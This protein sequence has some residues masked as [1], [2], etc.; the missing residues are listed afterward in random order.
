MTTLS[1]SL[2]ACHWPPPQPQG[3]IPKESN[4][5]VSVSGP[6]LE[7]LVSYEGHRCVE[8]QASWHTHL[9]FICSLVFTRLNLVA[10]S[11]CIF[12]VDGSSL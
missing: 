2:Q 4:A 3:P 6:R 5:S 7:E 10:S 8:G 12:R 9:T 1:Y 11:T